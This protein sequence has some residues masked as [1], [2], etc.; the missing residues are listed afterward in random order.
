MP[1]ARLQRPSGD[2]RLHHARGAA[3][4]HPPDHSGNRRTHG[5]PPAGGRM[6]EAV[7]DILVGQADAIRVRL[8]ALIRLPSVSTDPAYESGMQ[9]TRDYLLGW[10]R[11]IGLEEVQQLDGG[12]H[13][14]LYGSWT[15]A[16]GK[17]T[18]LIYGHY[19]V[20]PPDPLDEW[21]SP[22]FEPTERNG[23]LFGR[24]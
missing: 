17:P 16:P 8:E 20:Q 1:G 12:G 5:R 21:V 2:R 19:D 11:D 4:Q 3:R 18:L 14:A 23:C 22:P 13:P 24:G 9:A 15:G 10:F 6:S 7:A